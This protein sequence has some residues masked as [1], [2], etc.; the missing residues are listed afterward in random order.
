MKSNFC[1][2][3]LL[4]IMYGCQQKG[5]E[6]TLVPRT[7]SANDDFNQFPEDKKNALAIFQTGDSAVSKRADRIPNES[8][9]VKYGD[10]SLR[11]Q[12]DAADPASVAATFSFA[13]FL[14][15]QKT[16]LLVQVAD[17]SGLVQPVYLIT[18]NDGKSEA[19][20]LY[21]ASKGA[22][23]KKYTKGI[24]KVGRS[25]YL[26]NND[27]FITTVNAKIYSVKRQ[28][29]EERI[30]GVFFVNS[31]DKKTLVFMT[32]NSLYEVYYPTGETLTQPLSSNFPKEPAALFKWVQDN[33]SWQRNESGISFLK[34]NADDNRII[35]IKEFK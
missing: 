13:E 32:S 18:L 31:P 35:D 2:L 10:T 19:V 15:T 34:K 3:L 30:Q 5:S 16:S 20:S 21:L 24:D 17:Q 12:M 4:V 23:D 26:I 33:Y 8:Y 6:K 22:D 29:P 1:V 25:G 27:Y 28:K 14:N 11:I 7:L 9:H